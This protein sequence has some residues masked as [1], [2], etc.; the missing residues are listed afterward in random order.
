MAGRPMI[1]ISFCFAN[2]RSRQGAEILPG[3]LHTPVENP[4]RAG[5]RHLRVL[6]SWSGSEILCEFYQPLAVADETGIRASANQ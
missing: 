5:I 2:S 6:Q 4:R 1:W 3:P